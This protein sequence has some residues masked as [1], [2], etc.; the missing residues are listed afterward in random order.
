[1]TE[2]EL[3]ITLDAKGL[4]ALMRHPALA[5]HRL[6]PRRREQLVSIYYDTPGHAL[7]VAGIGLRLRRIGRRWVQT[8]KV[9]SGGFGLFSQAEVEVPAPGGR[10]VLDGPDDSGVFAAI[11]E[12]TG[13][14]P[15]SPVFETRI[16]RTSE[17]LE[18]PGG[19]EVELA[20]DAGEIVAG[21]AS[22]PI[23]EAELELV[24]GQVGALYDLAAELFPRG[25]VQFS[26]ANKAA[27]GYRLARG[28]PAPRRAARHAGSLDYPPEAT[29]ETVARDVFR[30][31]FAQIAANMALIASLD[32]PEVPHQF[33]VGLRRL[34]AAVLVFRDSLGAEALRPLADEARR[35]GQVVSPLRD[36]DVLIAEVVA[37]AAAL[38]L[39]P[40][41]HAALVAALDARRETARAE[42]RAALA[43][44][45]AVG[46]VFALGRMIEGRGWLAPMDY[47]QSARLAAPIGEVA[48]RMLDARLA[49]ARKRGRHVRRLDAEGLHALR[50]ELKKLRY[51]ADMLA[52]IFPKKRVA[53]Y[54]RTLKALQDDFGSL[55]DAAMAEACLTGRGAPAFGDP[56][57]QRAV[58]WVLGTL[59][60][61]MAHDRPRLF[62]H[63]EDLAG[64]KPFW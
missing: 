1:M 54:V 43:A 45:E 18:A 25:P 39:D 40:P 36:L 29:V 19:G 17:R 33:R 2:T 9:G 23:H 64:A 57:A 7:A 12:A 21:E 63:W 47:A 11:A 27:H 14:A 4:K 56:A 53:G 60:V 16:R 6:A 58:G 55:N 38:G 48:P 8:V 3:K 44:P 20:L 10:L 22:A 13:G 26:A 50:K 59:A 34:R 32:D 52:P 31:C 5:R 24:S 42:V 15:L 37:D 51:A 41:A 62:A 46:F 61:R 49:R 30:D 28:E 35:L